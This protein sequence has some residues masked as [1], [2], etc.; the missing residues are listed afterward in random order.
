[1]MM[2]L[3][4]FIFGL[5]TVAYQELQRQTNWR[6][7]ST[8]RI[9]VRPARQFMGPGDDSITLPGILLPGFK[10]KAE[11]I[12]DLRRMGD[13]GKAWVL[14]DGMGFVHGAFVIESLSEN[15][16]LFFRDGA[17][18]KID[19]TLNLTR[20]DEDRVEPLGDSFSRLLQGYL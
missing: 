10:G 12:S 6:H 20:V 7:G 9:G 14:V 13:S 4:N 11:Y 16:S 3:G 15:Q 5:E 2:A 19:F 8:S 18:R 17:A 1:M